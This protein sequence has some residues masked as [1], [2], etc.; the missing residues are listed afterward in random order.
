MLK[1]SNVNSFYGEV[2]VLRD[3]NLEVNQ[4]E[5]VT[6]IGANAAGKSTMISCISKTV[7]SFTGEIEFEGS[8]I[9]SLRPDQVVERGLI[10]VPEGRLLFPK[11]TVRENLELG[12]FSKRSRS[13]R[14]QRLEY[15]YSILP[16][17]KERANQM[18]G[19]L[20]GGEAQMCAIG[21]GLMADPKLLMF[22]EPSLGLA[23]IIVLE[24]M[25]L[26]KSIRN[27]GTTVLLIEQNVRQ[28]LKLADR[29]YVIEN[30]R[31]LMEGNGKELLG[32]NEV[33]KAYL[34]I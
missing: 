20:S 5:I 7:K 33:K 17:M 25:D 6:V 34:G 12:A 30:G 27:E 9:D 28:S 32:S 11:L 31:I 10:Q 4:G 19:S 13:S 21:R 29:A 23:P 26:I 16:K 14:K 3:V 1:L 24:I 18:A 15:V 8:R 22:D 2:Q